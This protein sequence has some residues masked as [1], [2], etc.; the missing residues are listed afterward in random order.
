MRFVC[1]WRHPHCKVETVLSGPALH[2]GNVVCELDPASRDND[3]G[4]GNVLRETLLRN[5]MITG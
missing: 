4:L 2:F 1:G 3:V 5:N